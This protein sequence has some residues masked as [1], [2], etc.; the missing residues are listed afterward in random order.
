MM[1]SIQRPRSKKRG[2]LAMGKTPTR[3]LRVTD[4]LMGD[5]DN[6]AANQ[7]DRPGRS[8][9]IRRLVELGLT[10]AQRKSPSERL[11]AARVTQLAARTIDS[12]S[13][14][15]GGIVHEH[16]ESGATTSGQKPRNEPG[17][18]MVIRK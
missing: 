15:L 5:V 13:E 6:W 16:G 4:K 14:D 3:S 10:V 18:T 9:A 17:T 2:R 7:Q 12:L 8:E 11:Q 1:G